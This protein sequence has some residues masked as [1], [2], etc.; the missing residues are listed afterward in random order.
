MF[1]TTT[2]HYLPQWMQDTLEEAHASLIQAQILELEGLGARYFRKEILITDTFRE[3]DGEY[4]NTVDDPWLLTEWEDEGFEEV[5]AGVYVE[6]H[7]KL[8]YEL[9]HNAMTPLL[10]KWEA[11]YNSLYWDDNGVGYRSDGS[12]YDMSEFNIPPKKKEDDFPF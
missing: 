5:T 1:L 9:E 3:D 4:Y 11:E 10:D 6:R 2:R 7:L 12:V 8:L